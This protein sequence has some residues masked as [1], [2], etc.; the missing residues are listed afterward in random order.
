MREL[1]HSVDQAGG[2]PPLQ[3]SIG[4]V[5]LSLF[6]PEA[7]LHVQAVKRYSEFFQDSSNG[8]P[9]LLNHRKV[10]ARGPCEFSYALD[11]ATLF[12][13]SRR[14]EFLGVRH[15]YAMDSLL[16]ILLTVVLLP[17]RGFLLHAA[18]V[19]RDGRAYIFVG[20]SGAGKST[21]ASLSPEGNVLTDE[22]SLL[23]YSNGCWQA[24]GT[25]FWGEFRAAGSNRQFPVAG[26]YSLVQAG[27]DR[28]EPLSAKQALR[29]LLPCV[30]FFTSEN[31]AH[32]ALL[33]MLLSLIGEIPCH[34]LHFRRKAEFW[35]VIAA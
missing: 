32:E 18:T 26:I 16:R 24:H 23:R 11:D 17:Q 4:S 31:D 20:R 30:L 6:I 28:V 5:P 7:A 3:V 29:A 27:S 19:I 33:K 34:R 9:I 14:A 35:K 1:V 8:L 22:I 21:V 10:G 15:E 25:P 13:G 2:S 12:F